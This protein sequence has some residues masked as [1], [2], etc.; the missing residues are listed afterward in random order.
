M[1]A[2]NSTSDR[3]SQANNALGLATINSATLGWDQD[4]GSLDK[5]ADII[6]IEISRSYR[7]ATPV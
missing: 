2:K 5:F 6:A 3:Q 4:I 1:A 7:S